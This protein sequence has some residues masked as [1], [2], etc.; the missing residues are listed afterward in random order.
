[1]DLVDSSTQAFWLDEMAL[2][3]SEFGTVFFIKV[4]VNHLILPPT[5]Y[6]SIWNITAQDM[7]KIQSSAAGGRG[8]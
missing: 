5:K 7:S 6:Q 8:E 3:Q 4:V 1:V 2:M